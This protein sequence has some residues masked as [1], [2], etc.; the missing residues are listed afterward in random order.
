MGGTDTAAKFKRQKLFCMLIASNAIMAVL[1]LISLVFCLLTAGIL[2][3]YSRGNKSAYFLGFYYLTFVC[4][5]AGNGLIRSQ[6][7]RYVPFMYPTGDICWL[8]CMPLSWLYIRTT[9][10]QKSLS[11]WDV[12][13]LLPVLLYLPGHFLSHSPQV[14][15]RALQTVVYWIMQVRLLD[16][17][18]LAA[19][20]KKR[21][22]LSWVTY[23]NYL[24]LTFFIPALIKLA[25][26]IWTDISIPPVIPLTGVVLSAMTLFL[27]PHI[28]YSMK[29]RDISATGRTKPLI[30]HAFIHG[31]TLELEKI[32]L[33]KK[34]FLNPNYTL[35]DLADA[36]NVPIYKL[37][38]CLNQIGGSNFSEYLNQWRIHY[39]LG[40]IREKKIVNLNLRGIAAKCGFNNRNTFSTAFKKVTGKSPSDYLHS[41]A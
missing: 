26:W 34:P 35:K 23:F 9:V 13:H 14:P 7:I 28:L 6:L 4:I 11:P 38:A 41:N 31:L 16:P 17:A 3:L 12:V 22:L 5:F 32:M 2:L 19:L 25:T 21:V 39:C 29:P 40:L 36:T 27:Y 24:Q 33:E 1:C 37:S 10:T 30:D 8:L 20:R 18:H 15:I